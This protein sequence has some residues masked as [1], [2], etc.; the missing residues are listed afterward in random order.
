MI[1]RRKVTWIQGPKISLFCGEDL[2]RG[3]E[4]AKCIRDFIR[5][6]GYEEIDLVEGVEPPEIMFPQGS[7]YGTSGWRRF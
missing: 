6:S 4:L 5:A 7:R 2:K 1:A 3:R